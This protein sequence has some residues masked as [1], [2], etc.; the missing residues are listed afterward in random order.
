VIS[1]KRALLVLVLTLVPAMGLSA[2][3]GAATPAPAWTITTSLTSPTNFAPGD[4]S[5]NNIYVIQA[6]NTGSVPIEGPVTVTDFLPPGLTLNP[7]PSGLVKF[8]GSDDGEDS[9]TCDPGPPVT[10]VF[11]AS[12]AELGGDVEVKPGQQLRVHVPVNVAADA[13]P[14]AVNRVT[15]SGFTPNPQ[16]QKGPVVFGS[17]SYPTPISAV[18]AP[19]GLQYLNNSLLGV[20]GLAETR[21][22]A[23]PYQLRVNAQYNTRNPGGRPTESP[24]DISDDLPAGLVINPEATPVR[25]TEAQLEEANE[26]GLSACPNA[27]AVGVARITLATGGFATAALNQPIY[28]MVP[29]QGRPASLA[30]NVGGFKIIIHLLG[31]LRTD[32]KVGLSSDTFD[33]PQLANMSGVSIDLWGNP[34][35]RSH[36][37]NRGECAFIIGFGRPGGCPTERTKTAFI[38]MPSACSGPLVNTFTTA[39]WQNHGSVLSGSSQSE[40][41]AG[42]LTGVDD[43][44]KLN[45]TPK[46]ETKLSTNQGETGTGLDVDVDFPNNGL[47]DPETRAESTT[48]KVVVTLPEGVTINPSVGEGLGSCTPAQYKKE[49]NFTIDGE[50]CPADS[51][52]G[53]LHVDTPLLDEGVDGFVYLAQQD[54]PTTTTP[55]VENPFDTDVALYMVLRNAA[56]G[57]LVK[58]ELKV[59]PDP[60]TGQLVATLEDIPQL[61]FSHF[62]FHFREGARA[63][64]VSPAA[65]GKYTTVAKFYPWSDPENPRFANSSFEIEKGVNGGPCP[66][67][68]LPPFKPVFEAGSLNNNANAYSPFNMRLRRKDGEQDMTK[69][70]SVL[71]PG[72]L[73][74][75]AGVS[76]CPDS[77]IDAARGKT[78]RQELASPSCPANSQIGRTYAG[79]GVGDSLT[80]VPG[81]LFLGGPYHGDPLSVISITPAL[82]GPFD[83]G[84]VVVREALTLNPETAEVIVDGANSD[85]IPHILK[86]IVLKVRDLR[87]YVDRPDF[88]VNPTSCDPTSAKATLFG[89]YLSVFDPSDD[90]PVDLSTRYQAANCLNLGFKPKLSINL[91]G[92]TKRGGHPALKAVVKANPGDANIGNAVVTLPQSAFLDQ[93]HIRTICTR[94]QYAA[95]GGS[96]GGCPKAAQYGYA[97]AFTPLLDEPVE[98]P[99]YLRSSNHKLPDLVAA[100]HGIVDV[101]IVGR[102]DSFKGRIRSSFE[103]IPDAAVTRFILTMQGG[104]KGL[105]VNSKN[106]CAGKNRAIANFTGQNGVPRTFRPVVRPTGCHRKRKRGHH[107]K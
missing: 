9:Y 21:A 86:G 7:K 91:K 68:G 88:I 28:N 69:F 83:A 35:D 17:S 13:G 36:D 71:P 74:K 60:K 38:T 30:F 100:L 62:N 107:K 14:V 24:R 79:A 94:V 87:V 66:P 29:P 31:R 33:I 53:T 51:K 34:S 18:P 84:T 80:Y 3:A 64:L 10:C 65:C 61:P 45:F 77:A 93:A 16:P 2:A 47:A 48:K 42:N 57:V 55:G 39:S 82:A 15:V 41:T 90:V 106:L 12:T 89:A 25:C 75:L 70:S 26:E 1:A 19:F 8:L 20:D 58:Q 101:D 59:E 23:H 103:T 44:K 40:D 6:K 22:G 78:G 73:G 67:A 5:G 99:V 95:N 4:N 52:V 63:T 54:D 49:G 46:T 50:G 92:G 43:C 32:G 76:K 37:F 96:G 81:K 104:K 97:R 27:S 102:I 72:V 85:P 105:V 56:R 98:G 11:D